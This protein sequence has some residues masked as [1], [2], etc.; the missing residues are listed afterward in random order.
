MSC[1]EIY[2]A[3]M[4]SKGKGSILGCIEGAI[5]TGYTQTGQLYQFQAGTGGVGSAS[6]NSAIE[7]DAGFLNQAAE[8]SRRGLMK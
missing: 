6:E 8:G 1:Q 3:R 5:V 4:K 7:D 2:I